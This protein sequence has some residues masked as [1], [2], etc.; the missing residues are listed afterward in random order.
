MAD[1]VLWLHCYSSLGGLH[2]GHG[3]VCHGFCVNGSRVRRLN[4]KRDERWLLLLVGVVKFPHQI[5]GSW[6]LVFRAPAIRARV[7]RSVAV[8]AEG[9]PAH[10]APQDVFLFLYVLRA[11]W[12][13][14]IIHERTRPPVTMELIMS[15]ME[16]QVTIS[17]MFSYDFRH[18]PIAI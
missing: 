5:L 16:G 15:R 3:V 2:V 13:E 14:V 10:L 11:P 1:W 6:V 17:A 8:C 18:C 4:R 9:L 12:A 7:V